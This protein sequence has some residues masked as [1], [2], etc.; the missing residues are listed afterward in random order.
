[1]IENENQNRTP[2]VDN[3]PQ[4]KNYTIEIIILSVIIGVYFLLWPLLL[5][6]GN[7]DI[8][9]LFLL[10]ILGTPVAAGAF[11]VLIILLVRKS[12]K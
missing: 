5:T 2:S 12:L 4:P 8:L 7:K 1:M 9:L 6:F 10:L 11:I 3:Q